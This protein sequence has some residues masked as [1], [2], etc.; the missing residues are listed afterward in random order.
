MPS[1]LPPNATRLER[2]LEDVQRRIDALPVPV[3]DVWNPDRCPAHLLPWLAW[4]LD[5]EHYRADW[6]E[7]V[8]RQAIAASW[9]AHAVMGTKASLVRA[10]AALGV[11]VELTEWWQTGAPAHTFEVLAWVNENLTANG[12]VLDARMIGWMRHVLDEYKPARSHYTFRV[13]IAMANRLRA[14]AAMDAAAISRNAARA[15][16]P[17]PRLHAGVR[18]AF[19]GRPL[20]V[21]RVAMAA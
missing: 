18:M 2:A 20:V 17:H 15:S 19:T 16:R 1:L 7:H 6:P 13:G 9:R 5:V 11:R 4:A 21:A 3:R 8:Q 10:F 12:P 14:G